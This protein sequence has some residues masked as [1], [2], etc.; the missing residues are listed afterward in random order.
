M[1]SILPYHTGH[2]A[3]AKSSVAAGVG[4]PGSR[5]GHQPGRRRRM[6]HPAPKGGH[7]RSLAKWP[8]RYLISA[9]A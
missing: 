4:S 6:S 9:A 1:V 8:L 7:S 3:D 5:R 2:V